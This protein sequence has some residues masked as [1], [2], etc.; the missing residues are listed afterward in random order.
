MSEP[1]PLFP[2][3][4]PS[5]YAAIGKVAANWAAFEHLVESAL[6]VLAGVDDEPGVCLTAQIPNTA[7]RFDVLMALVRLRGGSEELLKR[8]NKFVEDTYDLTTKRNRV[9]HDAW[10]WNFATQRALRLEIS[11]QKRLSYGF[12]E[13]SEDEIDAIVEEIATHIGKLD[14]IMRDVFAVMSPLPRRQR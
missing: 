9:I 13:M 3:L 8:I 14:A 5:H 6:W 11:A 1:R 12:I 4:P 7:R 2:T 10:H